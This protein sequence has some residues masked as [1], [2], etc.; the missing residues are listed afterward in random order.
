MLLRRLEIEIREQHLLRGDEQ[1]RNQFRELSAITLHAAYQAEEA[2]RARVRSFTQLVLVA[3]LAL[4]I[5]AVAL[6]LWA[7]LAPDV[8]ARFCSPPPRVCPLGS[9]PEA[10]SVFFLEFL[11]VCGA[12]VAGAVSLKDVRGTAGPYHVATSL[13]VLRI[14]VGALVAATG[15][16][17]VSAQFIPGL[18][19]LDTSTRIGAWAFAFGILQESVTRAVDRQGRTLLDAVKGPGSVTAD[20]DSPGGADEPPP[21]PPPRPGGGEEPPPPPPPT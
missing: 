16:L 17:L 1:A 11:G 20:P 13:I 3:A 2:Q 14:P 10:A 18:T 6:G 12:A 15:I 9:T 8:A 21:P 7:S 5:L 19:S 4:W